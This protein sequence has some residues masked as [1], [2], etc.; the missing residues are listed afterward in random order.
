M[1]KFL[2]PLLAILA[3]CAVSDAERE[4]TI[5]AALA[6]Y[7]GPEWRLIEDPAFLQALGVENTTRIA[8][9]AAA[10]PGD[11]LLALCNPLSQRRSLVV[12]SPT[13]GEVI[14]I[15]PTDATLNGR[16]YVLAHGKPSGFGWRPPEADEAIA[17][18]ES[19]QAMS[20]TFMDAGRI[21]FAAD[22]NG[23]IA[24]ALAECKFGQ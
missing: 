19:G 16:P 10:D 21:D 12:L 6:E 8:A 5:L 24:T 3:S 22:P 14:P 9:V 17:Q 11:Y 20:L 2:L 7:A 4:S 1:K 23:V 18:I 13:V 15:G